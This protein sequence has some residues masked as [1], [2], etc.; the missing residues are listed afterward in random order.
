MTNERT[1]GDGPS[2]KEVLTEITKNGLSKVAGGYKAIRKL[3]KKELKFGARCAGSV[4]YGLS[5]P[6]IIPTV[7]RRSE[8]GINAPDRVNPPSKYENENEKE[9]F[10]GL[11]KVS[12]MAS[13]LYLFVGIPVL[14]NAGGDEE[15]LKEF[16]TC[17]LGIPNAASMGYEITRGV[18]KGACYIAKNSYEKARGRIMGR[19]QNRLESL[20]EGEK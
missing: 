10:E 5:T 8:F 15:T 16:Y 12:S 4:A 2:R 18:A 6:L 7:L 14:A 9:L 17:I 3:G 1:Q 11:A 20:T 19:K 13:C